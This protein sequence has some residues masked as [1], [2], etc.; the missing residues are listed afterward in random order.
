MASSSAPAT[1]AASGSDARSSRYENVSLAAR[2][3]AHFSRGSAKRSARSSASMRRARMT[4]TPAIGENSTSARSSR[5]AAPSVAS[6][7]RANSARPKSVSPNLARARR[8]HVLPSRSSVA[9]TSAIRPRR[10]LARQDDAVQPASV[11]FAHQVDQQARPGIAPRREREAHVHPLRRGRDALRAR[12]QT[13]GHTQPR[14]SGEEPATLL[15]RRREALQQ[16][17][18]APVGWHGLRQRRQRRARLHE[19]QAVQQVEVARHDAEER[20]FRRLQLRRERGQA[21]C[22]GRG[23]GPVELA[24]AGGLPRGSAPPGSRF[25][26]PPRS[27]RSRARPKGRLRGPRRRSPGSLPSGR[28]RKRPPALTL[29]PPLRGLRPA[30]R[31][32]VPR[33]PLRTRPSWPSRARRASPATARRH[34]APKG[35]P[36]TRRTWSPW[37]RKEGR[38]PGKP[39]HS[40]KQGCDQQPNRGRKPLRLPRRPEPPPAPHACDI[41]RPGRA[42]AT[43]RR[44]TRARPSVLWRPPTPACPV[45]F[46]SCLH[47]KVTGFRRTSEWLGR[48]KVNRTTATEVASGPL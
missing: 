5:Q 35:R 21:S 4:G 3:S 38:P 7:C 1:T 29:T 9:A 26:P 32:G 6:R 22:P 27:R 24:Q 45:C 43:G 47:Y 36:A 12:S 48:Q 14:A 39:S 20:G 31:P 25:R 23:A 37:C 34:A 30:Q 15:A 42:S 18:K 40:R 8:A 17:G 41:R 46:L 2:S 44:R 28:R 11:Q 13:F 10:V 19:S 33:A 16:H